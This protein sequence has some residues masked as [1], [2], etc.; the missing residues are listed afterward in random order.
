MNIKRKVSL[1]AVTLGVL[2]MENVSQAAPWQVVETTD[3]QYGKRIEIVNLSVAKDKKIEKISAIFRKAS[4]D[5]KEDWLSLH[6]YFPDHLWEERE[7]MGELF[8][9][10]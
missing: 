10:G 9:F 8:R 7:K 4:G 1:I 3:N 2:V 6:V 5:F